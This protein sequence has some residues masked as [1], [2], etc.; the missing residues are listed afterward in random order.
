LQKLGFFKAN[1]I[2]NYYYAGNFSNKVGDYAKDAI[3]AAGISDKRY[4]K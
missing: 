3:E 2:T 4:I 1:P